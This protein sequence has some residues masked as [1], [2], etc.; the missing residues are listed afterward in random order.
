MSLGASKP[1]NL[2]TKVEIKMKLEF[3]IDRFY[4]V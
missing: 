4:C 3:D 2:N 1:K